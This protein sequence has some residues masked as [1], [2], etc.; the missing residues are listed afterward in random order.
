MT[1]S[2]FTRLAAILLSVLMLAFLLAAC[3]DTSEGDDT[4]DVATVDTTE[5]TSDLYDENGYLKDRIPAG[6]YFDNTTV[7][8]LYWKD[9]ENVEFFVEVNDGDLVEEAIFTRNARVEERLGINMEFEGTAGAYSYQAAYKTAVETAYKGGDN[10]YD[11]YAA[12][13][14]TTAGVAFSGYCQ[15]LMDYEIIDLEMPWWPDS[16]VSE[17]TINNKLY[18]V[19]GDLSTNMLY[20][21]YVLYFNKDLLTNAG[22]DSPYDC[23]DNKTWTYEKMY[24]YCAQIATPAGDASDSRIYGFVVSSNVHLDP[25]FYAAGLR[26]VD[27]DAEGVPVISEKFGSE[28][29]QDVVTSVCAFLHNGT[30]SQ[31]NGNTLFQTGNSLFIMHRARYASEYLGDV[32]MSYGIVPIPKFDVDQEAYATCMGFP[33]TM[34]AISNLAPNENA[35]AALIEC[36]ASEGYR[37]ITPALFEISMK[38]KYA[39][40]KKAAEMFDI[41]RGSVSFDIG[42]IY[43]SQLSN[44]TYNIFRGC[45]SNNTPNFNVTYK[46]S[47]AMIDKLLVALVDAFEE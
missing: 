40:D 20:M 16:L 43:T 8:I 29:T 38:V 11:I 5:D 18:L 10:P 39:D 6:T 31:S 45:V 47:E 3:G 28:R 26:T 32:D 33:Y 46:A 4:S 22:L 35:A 19:S 21:M 14:M 44:Y 34:Y 17:A 9:V 42:R 7:T 30:N 36:L 25:F 13:S 24:E 12:Y 23:V 41:I 15:N 27:R 37:T 1:K 2:T